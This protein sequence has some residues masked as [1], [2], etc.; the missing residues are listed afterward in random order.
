ML[1]QASL[2]SGISSCFPV[3]ADAPATQNALLVPA[4]APE[5]PCIPADMPQPEG[6]AA[7]V[8]IV[9][10]KGGDRRD[11]VLA[12]H[13][14]FKALA[15]DQ[16]KDVAFMHICINGARF[17]RPALGDSTV[18]NI[19]QILYVAL[20]ETLPKKCSLILQYYADECVVAVWGIN[21]FGVQDVLRR[22]LAKF[23]RRAARTYSPDAR[24]KGWVLAEDKYG[25]RHKVSFVTARCGMVFVPSGAAVQPARVMRLVQTQSREAKRK[26]DRFACTDILSY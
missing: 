8:D 11:D 15:C 26:P 2:R 1:E 16:A 6:R 21:K 13:P 14:V 25:Y 10:E 22:A 17:M 18:Q 5:E 3:P 19:E 9:P 7:A 4:V 20:D 12:D 23:E 24:Q